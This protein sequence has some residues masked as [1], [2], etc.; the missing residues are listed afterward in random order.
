[1]SHASIWSVADAKA[2]FS[3]VLTQAGSEPQTIT[4]NGKRAAVIVSA[5][6]WDLRSHCDGSLVDFLNHSPLRGSG[7]ALDRTK[8]EP[9]ATAL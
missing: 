8:D 3:E 4:R 7:L 5:E 9:R 2:N 1:M 6:A